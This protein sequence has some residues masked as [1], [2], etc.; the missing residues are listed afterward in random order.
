[1]KKITKSNIIGLIALFT[2]LLISFIVPNW[3]LNRGYRS[4]FNIINT[5]PQSYYLASNTAMA[6]R[7]SELLSSLDRMKLI[8][9]AWDSTCKEAT[10]ED[11]L[12]N[13]SAAVALAKEKIEY[14]YE[15]KWYP[16]S[17]NS[18]FNNWYSWTTELSMYQDNTFHTYNTVLWTITFTKYDNST[19]HTVLMTDDGMILSAQV[20][21]RT[22]TR[23]VNIQ[24]YEDWDVESLFGSKKITINSVT[25]TPVINLQKTI[26]ETYPTL[27]LH[28]IVEQSS[29]KIQLSTGENE[30]E[31]YILYQYKNPTDYGI[32]FLCP[33][34][35]E[36]NSSENESSEVENSENENTVQTNTNN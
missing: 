12:L 32:G 30:T 27:P 19:V 18:G 5:V 31:N 16:C 13:E 35:E 24:N 28:Q 3:L 14:L 20:N 36:S 17:L 23:N 29:Y 11:A 22:N 26:Q 2:I 4:H 9:G 21:D 15:N 1:M 10:P 6:K 33:T 34:T 25:T 7:K 8:T